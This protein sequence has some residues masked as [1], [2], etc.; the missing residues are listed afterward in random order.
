L[1]DLSSSDDAE[2]NTPRGKVSNCPS[3]QNPSSIAAVR[4]TSTGSRKEQSKKSA[5]LVVRN[6]DV[7]TLK[8]QVQQ[9]QQQIQQQDTTV[10][11]VCRKAVPKKSLQS[12]KWSNGWKFVGNPFEGKVFISVSN[13]IFFSII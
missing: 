9:Q 10:A 1:S 7:S 4:R 8:K 6:D 13:F 2:T 11:A 5:S 3:S 12:P